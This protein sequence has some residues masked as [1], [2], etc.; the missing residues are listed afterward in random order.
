MS[1]VFPLPSRG[2]SKEERH[3]FRFRSLGKKFIA[4]G[5]N[6]VCEKT[7]C[8]NA[9]QT[10]EVYELAKTAKVFIMEALWSRFMPVYKKLKEIIDSGAIGTVRFAQATFGY[11]IIG[12][13]RIL[14]PEMG[15]GALLRDCHTN[16]LFHVVFSR[17]RKRRFVIL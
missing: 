10:E 6:I 13:E 5:K 4:A 1:V 14:K 16:G 7:M 17:Y 8:L 9:E 15:G 11:P 3:I 12:I 2:T